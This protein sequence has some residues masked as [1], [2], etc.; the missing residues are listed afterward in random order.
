MGKQGETLFSWAP[1]SLQ[2]FTTAMKLKDTFSLGKKKKTVT[3]LDSI[4]KKRDFTL[5]TNICLVKA[6]VF[7]VVLYE[8]ESWTIKKAEHQGTDDFELGEVGED[9]W[10][11]LRL[12]EDQ[13]S[14]S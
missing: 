14:Q 13:A 4:L 12:Q 1:K 3:N 7:P 11:S 9:S 6:M 10:E 2:M 5:P 8:S